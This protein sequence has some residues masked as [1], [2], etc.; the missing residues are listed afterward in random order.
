[1]KKFIHKVIQKILSVFSLKLIKLEKGVD[2]AI[3]HL[4]P[5]R[6]PVGSVLIG[7]IIE[8]FLLSPD[9][10][11]SNAH[12]H[13]WESLQIARTFLEMGY[14][15]DVISYRNETF[16]PEKHY[17]V[18]IAARTNFERIACRLNEDCISIVHLD[19]AHWLFN[20]S[21]ACSRLYELQGR[22][23]VTLY[24]QKMIEENWAI[25]HA[26]C[27]TVLGN[28]F[29]IETYE[30]AKKPIY[31]VPISST[32]VY[33]WNDE[34]DYQACKKRFL[35]LGSTG[36]VH[37]G[38]SLVLETFATMPD[39]H[40]TVCGPVEEEQ[41]FKAAFY[42]ELFETPNIETAGWVDVDSE[43]FIEIANSCA[44]VI[45]PSCSEGGGGSVITCMH[46]GL[47]PVVS[48]ESSV[49]V[50]EFGVLLKDSTISEVRSALEQFSTLETVQLKRMSRQSWEYA[51][52]N[53]TRETFADSFR[54]VISGI[55][56]D[57][58]KSP[59]VPGGAPER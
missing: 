24:N 47:I 50:E 34:K 38:L 45:Y 31:R 49:D 26:D 8:P 54:Q 18:F 21:A 5:D 37:K 39:Y 30:Y 59:P 27:A 22:R 20:N 52:N 53:H 4:T 17:S 56:A 58:P 2:D 42:K 40:L 16:V 10:A 23:G 57:H 51:R 33:P 36:F 25:E 46:A 41:K 6:P 55:I 48:Y 12:T 35:W 29:T 14:A 32:S 13:D 3:V 7:Y 1:M 44:A 19:T 9:E 28:R 43:K 15:V 11:V